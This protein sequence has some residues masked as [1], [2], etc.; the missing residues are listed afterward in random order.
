MNILI[1]KHT[2]AII[3]QCGLLI[4]RVDDQE[5]LEVGYAIIPT[6][7][8]QGYATEAARKCIEYG[9]QNRLSNS[10]ISIIH[11]RNIE[12]QKVA[13]KNRMAFEKQTTYKGNPVKIFRIDNERFT[14]LKT[15]S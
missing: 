12:S 14:A 11:D 7:W 15:L 4:Q 1:H 3:G 13:I 10:I 2:G 8:N 9:L 6:Y 5:E